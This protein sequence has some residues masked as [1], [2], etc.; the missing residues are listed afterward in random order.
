MNI[1]PFSCLL[2]LLGLAPGLQAD[3]EEFS[4][5]YQA[6]TNGMRGNA[7]RH[8][9]RLDNGH[10]RLNTSLEAKVAGINVGDLEQVSEFSLTGGNIVPDNYQYLI[11]GITTENQ[12]ISF[13]WE[14]SL[15]RSVEDEQSWNIELQPGVLDQLSY[16]LAL[17]MDLDD[18][19]ETIFEYQL[20]DGGEIETHRYRRLG[21]EVLQTPLGP[22]STIK[23]ERIRETDNGRQTIIW[24]ARDWG[25]LLA[26]IEQINPSGLRIE[27]ELENALVA[28][29]QV[30]PLP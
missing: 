21:E 2:L 3:V 6:S 17:A 20:I 28:G 23:L 18:S 9:V 12:A 11:T 7:E 29:E 26:R 15:A 16:Q 5:Y 22:L 30:T 1:R 4:A 19:N 24:L 27:L 10:Y 13:N 25:N 14:A 8:L